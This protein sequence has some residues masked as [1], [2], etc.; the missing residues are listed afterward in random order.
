MG[1]LNMVEN[2]RTVEVLDIQGGR[3]MFCRLAVMGI[4]PGTRLI[5]VHNGRP[6]PVM[7]ALDGKRLGMGFGVAHR[8][9]VK[10]VN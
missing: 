1:P 8:I 4:F 10:P 2:G 5:M 3:G 9:L 7:V 6:G